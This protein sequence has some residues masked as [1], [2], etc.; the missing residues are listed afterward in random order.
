M[1]PTEKLWNLDEF[2][3]ITTT[4]TAPLIALL[5]LPP[6]EQLPAQPSN[7]LKQPRPSATSRDSYPRLLPL[8]LLPLPSLHTIAPQA[9]R[10]FSLS[11]GT[12]KANDLKRFMSNANNKANDS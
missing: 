10:S 4:V 6:P 5:Q 3:F 11:H 2:L 8:P 12:N 9:L 7:N 1:K